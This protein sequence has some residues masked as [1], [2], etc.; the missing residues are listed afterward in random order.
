MDQN[1]CRLHNRFYKPPKGLAMGSPISLIMTEIIINDFESKI[2]NGNQFWGMIKH[3]ARYVDDV[4]IVWSGTK[5]Q[6]D[7]FLKEMNAM[8]MDIKYTVVPGHDTNN[9]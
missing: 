5:R 7:L 3:W 2:L 9:E 6:V 1:Y 8:H 4:L